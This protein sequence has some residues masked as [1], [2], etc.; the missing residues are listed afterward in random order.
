MSASDPKPINPPFLLWDPWLGF[1]CK[2][3]H[4]SHFRWNEP[5]GRLWPAVHVSG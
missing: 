3:Q 1:C 5:N 4:R 2:G